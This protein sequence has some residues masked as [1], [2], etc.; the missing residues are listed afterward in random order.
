MPLKIGAYV[1]VS[2]EEQANV[3]DGSIVSQQHRIK[4]FVELKNHQEKSWGKVAEVYIDDG[5]SAKDT[6]RPAYQR[7]I[8]DVQAG[9]I[10]LLLVTDLSRLSRS[11]SDFCKLL[12]DLK[13][14]KAK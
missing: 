6:K 14:Y 10:N 12:E 1:R 9:R 5:Y 7:M 4:S 2:T 11:I 8:N 13:K 3:V